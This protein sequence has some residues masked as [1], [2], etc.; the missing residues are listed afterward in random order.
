MILEL[1]Q[2]IIIHHS[3]DVQ[4]PDH[5][6]PHLRTYRGAHSKG[7]FKRATRTGSRKPIHWLGTHSAG[8]MGLFTKITK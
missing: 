1:H 6:P 8:N 7:T 2:P 4:G 5:I 3:G